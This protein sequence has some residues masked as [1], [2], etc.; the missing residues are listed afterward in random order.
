MNEY[1]QAPPGEGAVEDPM[2]ARGMMPGENFADTPA[3]TEQQQAE[4]DRASKAASKG[5]E[6]GYVDEERA[7]LM[8]GMLAELGI[9]D[10]IPP[11]PEQIQQL[12]GMLNTH[13]EKAQDNYRDNIEKAFKMISSG[14][15]DEAGVREYIDGDF[16]DPSLIKRVVAGPDYLM[17]LF[18]DSAE[19]YP[20]NDPESMKLRQEY[21]KKTQAAILELIKEGDVA[22]AMKE[23]LGIGG[24]G[25]MP[26]GPKGIA[27]PGGQDMGAGPV[28]AGAD[29]PPMRGAK[30]AEDGKWYIQQNGKWFMVE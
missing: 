12:A 16:K 28:A 11:T 2:G 10:G 27:R 30:Q 26:T 1:Q 8:P 19:R 7:R 20:G 17:K 22:N 29:A 13:A 9:V 25:V 4:L 18:I 14:D 6:E 5:T 3:F 21:A 23:D 24:D 15:F